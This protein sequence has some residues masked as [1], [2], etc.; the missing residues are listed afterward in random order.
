VALAKQKP[1]AL[2][3][4]TSGVGNLT[5]VAGRLFEQRAGLS[6]IAV[7]YNTPALLPDTIS[8]T[9]S[10]TFN[11]LLTAVPLVTQG[12]LKALAITGDRRSPALPDTPTMTEAGIKDYNLTG[13][14]GILFPAGVPADRIK[15]IYEASAKA[16][17]TPGLKGIVEQNGLFVV[18]STPSNFTA[19]L[20]AD[21]EYQGKLMDELGLRPK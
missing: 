13:Y 19:F 9:V 2:S 12:Q 16:L 1:G 15:R 11:S 17:A 18:G 5:H 14:F 6:L 3:Y 8:G 7:P 4:A 20:K 10:M 21:Y